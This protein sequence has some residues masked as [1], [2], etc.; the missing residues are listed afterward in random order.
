MQEDLLVFFFLF[1]E[2]LGVEIV[3][4]DKLDLISIGECGDKRL[5]G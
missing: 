5:C 1:R 2:V 4:L 3:H